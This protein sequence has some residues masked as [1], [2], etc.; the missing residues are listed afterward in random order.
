MKCVL[1]IIDSNSLKKTPQG[2]PWKIHFF[3][4]ITVPCS[5]GPEEIYQA[6]CRS[7]VGKIESTPVKVLEFP[8]LGPI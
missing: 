7:E 5:L 2:A 4:Q 3:L 1:H 8:L 6:A